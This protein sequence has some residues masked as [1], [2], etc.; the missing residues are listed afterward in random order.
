MTSDV[1]EAR[2]E[3]EALLSEIVPTLKTLDL[4]D[5]Q[6]AAKLE[7][8]HA[9]R[10]PGMKR[11]REL[12][13]VGIDEGWLVPRDAGPDCKFG[14]LQK[15]MD[16]YAVDCVLMS[17]EALGHTH[18]RGEINIAFAWE[19]E[20]PRFDGHPAGWVVF[21]PGSHH[22]PTVTGGTMLFVYFMPGGEV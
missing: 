8:A 7:A 19:G 21:P 12:C 9:M 15:D 20:D 16:G 4:A 17:G 18:P 2:A 13:A 10:S 6:V 3:L 1:S 5:P 11:V 22:V 14:R